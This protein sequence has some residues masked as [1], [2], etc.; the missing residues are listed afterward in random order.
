M[1]KKLKYFL[2]FLVAS[3]LINQAIKKNSNTK[4]DT[5][6]NTKG[7]T[8]E[9]NISINKNQSKPTNATI[10]GLNTG[11]IWNQEIDKDT[12]FVSLLKQSNNVILRF[13][14]G[15]VAN[16]YQPD[17]VGY[18]YNPIKRP[19]A[20]PLIMLHKQ[21]KNR[22]YNIIENF[23]SLC[24]QSNAKAIYCVNV[25]NGSVDKML[26]VIDRLQKANIEVVGVEMG[27]EFNLGNYR[28]IFP[29]AKVYVDTIKNYISAMRAKH[30]NIP[31]GLIAEPLDKNNLSDKR[32]QFMHEWNKYTSHADFDAYVI[33]HYFPFDDKQ[34]IFD[35]I[36]L[37]SATILDSTTLNF[38]PKTIDYFKSIEQQK[39]KKIW[40]TE[41]NIWNTYAFNTF[42][43][44]AFVAQLLN[45][46]ATQDTNQNINITCMH[47]IGGMIGSA[48]KNIAYTYQNNNKFATSIFFPFQF[49]ANI[50]AK[51]KAQSISLKQ[52]KNIDL[53][54]LFA[55]YSNQ[56]KKYYIYFIN[57]SNNKI[58][59][60]LDSP[61]NKIVQQE[62]VAEK[63]Y[64][65]AGESHFLKQNP[66]KKS[67]IQYQENTI[68][69]NNITIQPYSLGTISFG[70]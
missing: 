65:N 35:N 26:Y 38:V 23:I 39:T 50:I 12:S 31:I 7:E 63:L 44:A 13:P 64:A 62:I 43:Q 57:T 34:K 6:I 24:K 37:K 46:L 14:G 4:E 66:T 25:L 54:K 55:Y 29:N 9:L 58:K 30:P 18:G 8:I 33:H 45:H 22:K 48:K 5:T 61:T 47:D 27:N 60:N 51:E 32:S 17:E 20:K 59:L 42:L 11:F 19:I 53:L 41:W 40:L 56:S 15:G 1:N 52:D 16:D 49:L 2:L 70:H 69:Q 10:F 21:T 36:Y 68:E 28:H 67:L 3:W